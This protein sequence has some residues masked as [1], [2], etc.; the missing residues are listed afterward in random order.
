[1]SEELNIYDYLKVKSTLTFSSESCLS[2]IRKQN[3]NK[4]FITFSIPYEI[5]IKW[6]QIKVVI[7]IRG[8]AFPFAKSPVLYFKFKRGG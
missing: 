2:Y 5:L 3:S 7:V 4:V 6:H 8:F 1:M